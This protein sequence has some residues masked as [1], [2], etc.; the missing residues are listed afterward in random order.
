MAD[1]RVGQIFAL[2]ATIKT[3]VKLKC[4]AEPLFWCSLGQDAGCYTMRVE[5]FINKEQE[6]ID[7]VAST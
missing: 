5:D 7:D 6:F 2:Q 1:L 3:R 4:N